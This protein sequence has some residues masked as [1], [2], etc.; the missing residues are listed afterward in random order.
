MAVKYGYDARVEVVGT[1][2]VLFVGSPS[3]QGVMNCSADGERQGPASPSWRDLFK[4]AYLAED[5]AFVE[6]IREDKS[7]RVTGRDGKMAVAVVNAGNQSIKERKPIQVLT[8]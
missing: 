4:D 6:C 1:R 5:N 3:G 7:P 2:G 8:S